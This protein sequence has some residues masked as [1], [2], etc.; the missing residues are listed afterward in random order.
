MCL[1]PLCLHVCV[2]TISL[3]MR[4]CVYAAVHPERANRLCQVKPNS[5]ERH[6]STP[7]ND[8]GRD[9]VFGVIN[10]CLCETHFLLNR[11]FLGFVFL[12]LS[13]SW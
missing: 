10:N 9:K 1:Y 3:P 13:P 11:N 6:L 8:P 5:Q 2:R 12:S 7:T 4:V